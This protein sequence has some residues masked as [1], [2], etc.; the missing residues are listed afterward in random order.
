[1]GFG[2]G[3]GKRPFLFFF[4]HFHC[5]SCFSQ[6]MP[7]SFLPFI[8]AFVLLFASLGVFLFLPNIVLVPHCDCSFFFCLGILSRW[9]IFNYFFQLGGES[10]TSVFLWRFW[11]VCASCKV[12]MCFFVLTFAF[13]CALSRY[14]VVCRDFLSTPYNWFIVPLL[15]AHLQYLAKLITHYNVLIWFV[16]VC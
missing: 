4:V 8:L 11:F 7:I 16:I 5:F 9:L 2:L 14:F 10:S 3:K 12:S 13:L 6:D 15:L 1:M